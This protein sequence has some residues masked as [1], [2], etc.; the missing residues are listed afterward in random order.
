MK[1]K[2]ILF[3]FTV[4]FLF[5]LTSCGGKKETTAQTESE[6][7][8]E[9]TKKAET[10][11]ETEETLAEGQ[12]YSYL[13][14]EPVEQAIGNKRPFAIMINNIEDA[15]PQ[16]GISQAEILYECLVEYNITRLL[17]EFQDIDHLN[18][19]GSVRSARHYYMDLASDDS[20]IFTHF[21]QSIFAEERIK[22]GY[23]T[24]SGLSGYS[25]SVF[26]RS[27]DR[28]APHNVYTSKDGLNAGLSATGI[29]R[30]YPANYEGRLNFFTSDTV[31]EE[32]DDAWKVTMPFEYNKP[33]FEYHEDDGLYYRFQYGGPHIDAENNEQL[34]F[35]NLI[36]QYADRSVISEQDHQDYTLIGKGTGLL[37][38]N[39]KA[40]KIL[41]ERPSESDVTKYYYE[42]GS[43]AYL[44]RGKSYISVVPSET[45]VSCTAK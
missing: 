45:A 36:I 6:T 5:C 27:D 8:A 19:V 25:E 12:M 7:Q 9:E 2:F 37:I 39:G 35:K 26:W 4:T 28:P 38:T 1:K 3:L 29:S 23:P 22:N 44:N 40:V 31:P 11:K 43:P 15:I 21:G 30:D 14:G 42:D 10:K 17:C 33:W 41:W 18:K 34:T 24:I 16:S 32:G 20:A 13:T